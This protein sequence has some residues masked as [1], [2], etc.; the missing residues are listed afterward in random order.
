MKSFAYFCCFA[1]GLCMAGARADV[2]AMPDEE[3]THAA[4]ASLPAKG[5]S[6]GE[7]LKHYGEPL[8][9]HPAAGGDTPKHPP[10]TRWDY[11]GF[12]VFFEHT[13]VVDSVVP[14]RPPEIS[15]VD[16]L[17]QASK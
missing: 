13:H 12:S 2:L 5:Q 17:Q 15:H 1:L 3:A 16:Q 8:T 7:V 6:M 9:K 10:I 4:P 14:G 11:Q